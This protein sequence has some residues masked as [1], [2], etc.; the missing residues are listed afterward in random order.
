MLAFCPWLGCGFG[1]TFW[2]RGLFTGSINM[3]YVGGG[4]IPANNDLPLPQSRPIQTPGSGAIAGNVRSLSTCEGLTIVWRWCC[5]THPGGA[6]V[7]GC[8][9]MALTWLFAFWCC[10]GYAMLVTMIV[11]FFRW[12][13]NFTENGHPQGTGCCYFG[14]VLA[15]SSF[16]HLEYIKWTLPT[17]ALVRYLVAHRCPLCGL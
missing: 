8:G 16:G 13:V 7:L 3:A 17:V 11:D 4:H 14:S 5:S 2:S 15:L 10:R 1:A 12:S 6:I 9:R